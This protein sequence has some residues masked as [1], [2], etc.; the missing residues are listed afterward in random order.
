MNQMIEAA[1]SCRK[2]LSKVNKP[3]ID[4]FYKNGIIPLLVNTL[5]SFNNDILLFEAAWAL[6]NIAS[7]ES[8]HTTAV[9]NAGAVSIFINLMS[10][11]SD[12]IAEQSI[13]ALSNIAGDSAAHRDATIREGIVDAVKM[14]I[15]RFWSKTEVYRH[16]CWLISNLFRHKSKNY[17]TQSVVELLPLIREMMTANNDTAAMTDLSWAMTY[18]C[19]SRD[20]V[21]NALIANDMLTVLNKNLSGPYEILSPSLRAIG[22]VIVGTN[23]QADAAIAAGIIGSLVPLLNHSNARVVKEACWVISNLCAGTDAQVAALVASGVMVSVLAVMKQVMIHSYGI[24]FFPRSR[25]INTD[26]V[27]NAWGR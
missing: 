6:T 3:P 23:E 18:A 7:G 2:Q 26:F 21:I 15:T 19:D 5:T 13:W 4:E 1:T 25:S 8:K 24:G 9:V 12:Q 20:A 11:T 16:L 10:H 17:P 14:T 22:N 27:L